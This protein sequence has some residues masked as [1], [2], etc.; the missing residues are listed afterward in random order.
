SGATS[1]DV[2][3]TQAAAVRGLVAAGKV[4]Y[5][6]LSVGAHYLPPPRTPP[7]PILLCGAPPRFYH[8][9]LQHFTTRVRTNI[10][11]SGV[12][13]SGAGEVGLAL[14]NI[15]DVAVTPAYASTTPP[16]ILNT[17]T[18]AE[19][20]ANQQIGSFAAVHHLPMIDLFALSHLS[21]AP[22]TLGQVT[23]NNLFAL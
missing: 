9:L 10:S 12:T 19:L 8:T 15:P 5:A 17:I 11:H 14:A 22:L 4:D 1:A 2:L 20:S 13:V 18:A 7:L 23:V 21:Q 6:S 3:N 16:F